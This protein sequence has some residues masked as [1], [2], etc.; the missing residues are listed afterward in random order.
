MT[1]RRSSELDI[2]PPS[3][4]RVPTPPEQSPTGGGQNRRKKSREEKDSFLSSIFGS[5]SRPSSPSYD[6]SLQSMNNLAA[7]SSKRSGLVRKLSA[8]NVK[9]GLLL[10]DEDEPRRKS[11][12]SNMNARYGYFPPEE[13]APFAYQTVIPADNRKGSSTTLS[14]NSDTSSYR[15]AHR[16]T[17]SSDSDSA[18]DSSSVYSFISNTSTNQTGKE[19]EK[20]TIFPRWF[21][22]KNP[23]D[24]ET[25]EGIQRK[26][27]D[28]ET[29]TH[30]NL[31]VTPFERDD[32]TPTT[33]VYSRSTSS[34]GKNEKSDH[35]PWRLK[36][37]HSGR[38]KVMSNFLF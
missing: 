12:D 36:K 9:S 7:R 25:S 33:P 16:R 24:K 18:L 8:G 37:G 17:K 2:S 22:R 34:T 10:P 23:K 27:S 21:S 35:I 28:A 5:H 3:P 32:F 13:I 1:P 26:N 11:F 4:F 6:P 29:Y 14:S 31:V 19:K 30:P 20:K 15:I 38:R